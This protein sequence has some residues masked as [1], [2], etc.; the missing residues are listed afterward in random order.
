MSRLGKIFIAFVIVLA[1]L[2]T[3]GC[4]SSCDPSSSSCFIL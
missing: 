2:T 4:G 1:P 3:A